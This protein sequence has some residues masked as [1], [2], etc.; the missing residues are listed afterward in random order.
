MFP[1]P[2][3]Q[4]CASIWGKLLRIIQSDNA[5]LGI[6]NHGGRDH[7]TEQR[8]AASFIQARDPRPTKLPRRT[9]ETGAAEA[10]HSFGL[11]SAILACRFRHS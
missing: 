2:F 5:A 9:L 8:T 3:G 11:P 6:E 7:R 10:C 4:L 1:N